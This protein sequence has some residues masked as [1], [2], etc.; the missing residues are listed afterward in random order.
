MMT[1]LEVFRASDGDL[2]KQFYAALE[3]HGSIGIVAVNL[4]RAQKCSSRAKE[5]R[6]RKYKGAAY[7]RK[8]WSMDNLCDTLSKHGATL[9]IRYGWKQDETTLFGDEASWV[10]YVEVPQGQVSFHSPLRGKGP[11]YEG[12]WD[13]CKDMSAGRIIQFCDSVLQETP[14]SATSGTASP[15]APRLVERIAGN[16]LSGF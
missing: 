15:N 8:Q 2:T 1:A 16:D 5:Y 11:V 6:G 14:G 7:D 3:E 9:G 12:E 10:L 13:R 4:F